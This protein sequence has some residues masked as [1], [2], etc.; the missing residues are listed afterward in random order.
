MPLSNGRVAIAY[1]AAGKVSDVML[2]VAAA[3]A[4]TIVFTVLPN[5][6]IPLIV[7][8]VTTR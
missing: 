4:N 2:T 7:C 3:A 6:S 8:L 5:I 1:R